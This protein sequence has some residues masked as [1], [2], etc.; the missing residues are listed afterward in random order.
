M[1]VVPIVGCGTWYIEV[2][3]LVEKVVNCC[4]IVCGG[5]GNDSG[6]VRLMVAIV[7]GGEEVQCQC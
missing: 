4:G 7:G 3:T 1:V 5:N 2:A 6:G